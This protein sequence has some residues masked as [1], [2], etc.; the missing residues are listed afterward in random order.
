[1]KR[2]DLI[3]RALFAGCGAATAP[4]SFA[5]S[6][7][8][9]RPLTMLVPF[10]P[11]A[12][13]DIVA[14]LV[15]EGMSRELQQ[16]I[17]IDNRVGAGGQ[18]AMQA[19]ANAPPDGTR[20]MLTV[21]GA[22]TILPNLKLKPPYDPTRDFTPIGR[23]ATTANALIVRS[24]SP[25]RNIADLIARAKREPNKLNYGSWGIG[26]G[27]HLAGEIVKLKAD[28]QT[29]HVAYKGT[30]EVVQSLIAGETDYA[31][32]GYGL[33]TSQSKG[34]AVRV[35]AVLGSQRSAAWPDT[36]TLKEAGY[37]FAQDA[38]FG[39]IGPA[40]MA[41]AVRQQLEAALQ[42]AGRAPAFTERLSK[43]GITAAPTDSAQ[44]RSLIDSDYKQ[45]AVWIDRLAI[46]KT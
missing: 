27:G 12:D 44:L 20:I 45:W 34:G 41:E 6:I 31:F 10:S 5:Q 43:L 15:A 42:R 1:M 39:V 37:D 25:I 18:I 16:P 19:V 4:F 13:T 35:L 30:A 29:V 26:S 3:Q 22:A 23:V 36:P 8:Q 24:D 7:A 11:G 46:P 9:G 38:W 40:G 28:V 14:R 17:V 32:V 21:Q 2:R 33:A